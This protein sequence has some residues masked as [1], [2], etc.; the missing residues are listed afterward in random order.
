MLLLLTLQPLCT[1]FL[2]KSTNSLG[3]LG[4][5][6]GDRPRDLPRFEGDRLRFGDR[7]GYRGGPRGATFEVTREVPQRISSRPSQVLV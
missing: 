6:P 5:P 1:L 7:D 3:R 2:K 4:D